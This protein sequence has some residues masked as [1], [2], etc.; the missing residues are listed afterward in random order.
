MK[1]PSRVLPDL[2]SFVLIVVAVAGM[3]GILLDSLFLL[4]QYVLLIGAVIA[5][6]CIIL[7][8]GDS[9]LRLA[10]LAILWLLLGAWRYSVSSP[11]GDPQS[12]HSFISVPEKLRY[13]ARLRTTRKYLK[14][15]A[16]CWWQ[17]TLSVSIMVL[18]SRMPTGKS[19]FKCLERHSTIP[20]GRTM[21]I[22]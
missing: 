8:W 21:V 4:P 10:S 1:Q 3:S 18:P 15:V 6:A 19:K 9:R 11:A 7:F 13:E 17:L 2:R 16:C 14:G 20:T 22:M 12:I 5:L